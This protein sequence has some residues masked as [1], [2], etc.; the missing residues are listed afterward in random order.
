[1]HARLASLSFSE[2]IAI[3]EKLRDRSLSFAVV[4]VSLV[5]SPND[6]KA[7]ETE[8]MRRKLE[9]EAQKYLSSHLKESAPNASRSALHALLK[10]WLDGHRGRK[11]RFELEAGEKVKVKEITSIEE[12]NT[13]IGPGQTSATLLRAVGTCTEP[14]L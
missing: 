9:P 14:G 8:R 3:L 13:L 1:M 6:P 4:K 10:H 7:D 2:K 5:G 12:L 11:V